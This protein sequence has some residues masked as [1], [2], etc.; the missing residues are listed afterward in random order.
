MPWSEQ[1]PRANTAPTQHPTDGMPRS[2]QTG[3][4]TEGNTQDKPPG[5]GKHILSHTAV[6]IPGYRWLLHKHVASAGLYDSPP[7]GC[8]RVA[9]TASPVSCPGMA[10]ALPMGPAACHT[11]STCCQAQ[12]SCCAALVVSGLTWQTEPA[13]QLSTATQLGINIFPG[14]GVGF[15]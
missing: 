3:L 9:Q 6:C 10:Q 8:G 11:Q 7:R 14:R 15:P 1:Q 12:C 5:E 4:E 2:L 13:A